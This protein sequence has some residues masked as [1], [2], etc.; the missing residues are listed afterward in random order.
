MTSKALKG[1]VRAL[2]KRKANVMED[3]R[4][5]VSSYKR[6]MNAIRALRS[7]EYSSRNLKDILLNVEEPEE[8][9]E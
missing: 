1:N 7:E 6:Q 3:F 8:E 2:L 9:F 5:N 4:A